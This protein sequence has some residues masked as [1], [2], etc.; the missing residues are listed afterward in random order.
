MSSSFNMITDMTCFSSLLTFT[1]S[2]WYTFKEEYTF[3]F[4]VCDECLAVLFSG[5]EV[6]C[7][8]IIRFRWVYLPAYLLSICLCVYPLSVWGIRFPSSPPCTRLNVPR[9]HALLSLWSW[10]P[11]RHTASHTSECSLLSCTHNRSVSALTK[12]QDCSQ[13]ESHFTD[14]PSG[15]AVTHCWDTRSQKI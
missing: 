15:S 2:F 4:L 7:K 14:E 8:L 12:P 10:E 13:A 9:S 3:C 1:E 5:L 6:N 11:P